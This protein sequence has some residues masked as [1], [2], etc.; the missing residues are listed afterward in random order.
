[1]DTPWAQDLVQLIFFTRHI[2]ESG[3]TPRVYEW[4]NCSGFPLKFDLV[5]IIN[6]MIVGSWSMNART[7]DGGSTLEQR[8]FHFDCLHLPIRPPLNSPPSAETPINLLPYAE[9]PLN[10]PPSTENPLHLPP[11]TET[12]LHPPLEPLELR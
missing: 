2:R 8:T 3:T 11:S 6:A 5:C 1:V 12:L 9:T 7:I 4:I 10:S